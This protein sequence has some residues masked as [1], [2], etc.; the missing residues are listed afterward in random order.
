MAWA[1]AGAGAGF[2]GAEAGAAAGP[3]EPAALEEAGATEAEGAAAGAGCIS[4]S[5]NCM[6]CLMMAVHSIAVSGGVGRAFWTGNGAAAGTA[7]GLGRAGCTV[8]ACCCWAVCCCCC[9]PLDGG[10]AGAD[11]AS[12]GSCG[13]SVAF[14]AAAALWARIRT[15]TAMQAAR[16]IVGITATDC[17]DGARPGHTYRS[18]KRL[19]CIVII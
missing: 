17:Y 9:W 5:I 15:I 16:P 1:G 19:R 3:P 11:L 7:A 10:C 8:G 6:C 18:T 13:G 4:Q 14:P 12:G 2:E